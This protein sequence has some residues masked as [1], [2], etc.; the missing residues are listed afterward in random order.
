M[1]RSWEFQ[2]P[3]RVVMGRGAL[4]RLGEK[5]KELGRSALLVEYAQAAALEDAARRALASLQEAGLRVTR[6]AHVAPD[7]PDQAAL[8]GARQAR[9]AE[10]DVVVAL[11]GGSVIDAAKAIAALARLGGD[12]WEYCS[13]NKQSRPA[14]D[15]LPLVAIPTTAGTGAEVTSVAVLTFHQPGG[16]T[17][18]ALKGAIQGPALRPRVALVDPDLALG[19]PAALAAASGADA[20]GHAVESCLSR[21]ANPISTT[22]AWRAAALI[23]QQLPRAV[24]APDD[25]EP[26]EALA[27]AATLAGAAF[28]EAGVVVSHALAH[29]LGAVLN[30]PHSLGIAVATPVVLRFNAEACTDALAELAQACGFPGGSPEQRAQRFVET[31]SELLRSVGLPDRVPLPADAPDDVLDRLVR[32]A[33]ESSAGSIRLNPRRVN[34]ASLRDLFGQVLRQ[35]RPAEPAP[36]A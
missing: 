14:A 35:D 4:R 15:A 21:A 9:E 12:P 1:L 29:A 5:A 11:G 16:S 13:A 24:A 32:N 27:L 26:R 6:F 8:E 22:L 33:W 31:V 30:V 36:P 23:V 18:P 28:N 10:A 19:S 3:T 7:P 20:L 34:D 17:E 25:P 2:L